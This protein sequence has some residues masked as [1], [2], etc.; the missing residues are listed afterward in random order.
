MC[1]AISDQKIGKEGEEEEDE[2]GTAEAGREDW[3][4]SENYD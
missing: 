1:R 4:G 2:E 3:D